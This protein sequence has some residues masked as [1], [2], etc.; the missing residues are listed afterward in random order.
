MLCGSPFLKWRSTR[1]SFAQLELACVVEWGLDLL[2]EL[3]CLSFTVWLTLGADTDSNCFSEEE[4]ACEILC[5]FL[6]KFLFAL[7]EL[8]FYSHVDGMD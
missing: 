6:L 7:C 5:S 1:C 4:T 3:S 8:T 2:V